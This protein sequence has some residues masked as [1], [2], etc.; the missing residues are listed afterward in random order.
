MPY[1]TSIFWFFLAFA[2]NTGLTSFAQDKDQLVNIN[3]PSL[4][5][6]FLPYSASL[7]YDSEILYYYNGTNWIIL[8]NFW[9]LD[10]NDN[11]NEN[12]FIGCI[13]FHPLHIRTNNTVRMKIES[14]G[15][16]GINLNSPTAQFQVKGSS[17]FDFFV[18]TNGNIGIGTSNPTE[19]LH[20]A[21]NVMANAFNTPD[22]VFENYFEVEVE[23]KTSYSFMPLDEVYEFVR[24]HKHLPNVPSAKTIKQQGGMIVNRATERNLEK[25][26][27]LY[28]HL[29]ELKDKAEELEQRID[30]IKTP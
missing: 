18:S 3:Y 12:N 26:E 21:G 5:N 16:V 6:T 28:L 2:I 8:N 25:I 20:V 10:G 4:L 24:T 29:F 22:Y 9:Q 13:N 17:L 11:I 19:R 30:K 14:E 27:E 15:N 7:G 23:Q 1:R